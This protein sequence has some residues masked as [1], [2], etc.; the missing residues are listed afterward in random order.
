MTT[1]R[2]DGRVTTAQRRRRARGQSEE[3]SISK[4]S[5]PSRIPITF[6][7]F[8]VIAS[9]HS[10]TFI[11]FNIRDALSHSIRFDHHSLTSSR[12]APPPPP[13]SG[14]APKARSAR[15]S[16]RTR[17]RSSSTTAR[18]SATTRCAAGV[19]LVMTYHAMS[20]SWHGMSPQMTRCA[21]ASVDPVM[22]S[23]GMVGRSRH[24]MSRKTARAVRQVWTPA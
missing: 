4:N 19:D 11:A 12:V 22:A 16:S 1:V 5:S 10:I 17:C 21:T 18:A 24:A 23:H 20:M 15:S 7:A 8:K 6:I 3:Q 13:R 14:R 2:D 9:T